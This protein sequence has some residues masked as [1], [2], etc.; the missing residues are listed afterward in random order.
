MLISKS[1][2]LK[3]INHFLDKK[4]RQN[5]QSQGGKHKGGRD[6]KDLQTL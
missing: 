5:D 3:L 2:F 1:N 6:Q 4:Y